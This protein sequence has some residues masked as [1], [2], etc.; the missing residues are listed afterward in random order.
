MAHEWFENTFLQ[1][2][3]RH[4]TVIVP[5]YVSLSEG[6]VFPIK[7]QCFPVPKRLLLFAKVGVPWEDDSGKRALVQIPGW[8]P[9]RLIVSMS[10][11][12]VFPSAMIRFPSPCGTPPS[13]M[14][15]NACFIFALRVLQYPVSPECVTAVRGSTIQLHIFFCCSAE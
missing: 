3:M 11:A 13:T 15:G 10:L 1:C 4:L 7:W 5:R 12:K 6:G 9:G 14:D 2:D 8:Q